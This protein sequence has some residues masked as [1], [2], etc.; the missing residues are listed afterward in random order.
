MHVIQDISYSVALRNRLDIYQPA[1]ARQCPVVLVVHGGAWMIGDKSKTHDVCQALC[2]HNMVV[3]ACNYQLSHIPKAAIRQFLWWSGL[4]GTASMWY[5]GL[6]ALHIAL[7]VAGM[8]T[9]GMVFH[10]ACYMVQPPYDNDPCPSHIEDVIK[11]LD[12]VEH[13][14][15]RYG[16][17]PNC[18]FLLGHSAGA[19]LVSLLAI[20]RTLNRPDHPLRGVVCISGVYSYSRMQQVTMG[21]WLVRCAFGKQDDYV[22][23]FPLFNVHQDLPPHLLMNADWDLTLQR[24]TWDM[25]MTLQQHGVFVRSEHFPGENHFSIMQG[26]MQPDNKVCQSVWCFIKEAFEL[27][28]N[29]SSSQK[30]APDTVPNDHDKH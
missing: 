20:R 25:H 8:I 2:H 19:H 26:W 3:V 17:D 29:Q 24:H 28:N 6:S 9:V 16:G 12:W 27:Y 30:H 13:H 23:V 5:V 15:D 10:V 11:A 7:F 22:H 4:L 21:E 18:L 14:I 1:Q